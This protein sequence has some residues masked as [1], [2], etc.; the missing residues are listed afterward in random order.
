MREVG[1]G[2]NGSFNV[3]RASDLLIMIIFVSGRNSRIPG[4]SAS[5]PFF[6]PLLLLLLLL[7]LMSSIN[8]ETDDYLGTPASRTWYRPASLPMRGQRIFI[9]W[10]PI[11]HFCSDNIFFFKSPNG[12]KIMEKSLKF[13]SIRQLINFNFLEFL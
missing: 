6:P 1:H 11:T 3:S 9:K 8:I 12:F 2:N 4:R 5:P 7:L 10:P 13:V